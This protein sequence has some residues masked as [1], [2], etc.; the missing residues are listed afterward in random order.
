[1][2]NLIKSINNQVYTQV[3]WKMQQKQRSLLDTVTNITLYS[4][5]DQLYN[6]IKK[7]I[8]L[9]IKDQIFSHIKNVL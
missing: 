4:V 8:N 9:I 6:G 1:M 7:D 2:T 5:R 3:G